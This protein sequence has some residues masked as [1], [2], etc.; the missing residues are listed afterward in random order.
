MI[1]SLI[2]PLF[3]GITCRVIKSAI[4]VLV[5]CSPRP[6]QRNCGIV[7]E[8]RD[9]G[10]IRKGEELCITYIARWQY[11]ATQVFARVAVRVTFRGC[12]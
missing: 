9:P 3:W 6:K 11:R 4:K 8:S 12:Q 2:L 1:G 5:G 7:R 10:N